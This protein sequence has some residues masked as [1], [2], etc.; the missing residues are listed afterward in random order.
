[1]IL[2]AAFTQ[3]GIPMEFVLKL[4]SIQG[5]IYI[6]LQRLSKNKQNQILNIQ[7]LNPNP[8]PNPMNQKKKKQIHPR[9][10]T[11]HQPHRNVRTTQGKHSPNQ[12][13]H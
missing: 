11:L 1:M 12:H 10:R 4:W 8:N 7:I 2:A 9:P 3:Q 6:S 13:I 5:Q